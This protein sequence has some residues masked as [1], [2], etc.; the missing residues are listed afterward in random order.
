MAKDDYYTTEIFVS[1]VT[2][3]D[4]DDGSKFGIRLTSVTDNSGGRDFSSKVTGNAVCCT[5]TPPP[6]PPEPVCGNGIQEPGEECDAGADNSNAVDASCRPDCTLKRCGDGVKD[7]DEQCDEGSGNSDEA[8]ATCRTDC[9][10]QRCG[11]GILDSNE[12]CDAGAANS[13]KANAL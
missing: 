11:D 2:T 5:Y 13:D 3:D 8:G 7:S 6:T 10:P 4:F 9:K 1:G 12:E